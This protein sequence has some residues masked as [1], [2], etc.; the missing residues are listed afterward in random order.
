MTPEIIQAIAEH[1]ANEPGTR[2]VFVIEEFEQM[3][4]RGAACYATSFTGL[5]H[6]P[7]DFV[8]ERELEHEIDRRRE[9]DDIVDGAAGLELISELVGRWSP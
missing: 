4:E 1:L 9:S 2:R 6:E 7:R 8:A 5:N 3:N